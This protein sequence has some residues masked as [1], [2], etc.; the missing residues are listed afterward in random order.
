MKKRHQKLGESRKDELIRALKESEERY[1]SLVIATAQVV[2]TTDPD[3]QVQ[4][5]PMWREFTGQSEEEVRGWGWLQALHP[6][7]REPTAK[8][9]AEAVASK[10]VCVT[11]YRVRRHD[12]LYR[13][14]AV[15]GVPVLKEDGTIREWVGICSDI[16]ESKEAALQQR[17]FVRDV[18]FSVSEGKLRLCDSDMDLPQKLSSACEAVSLTAESLRVLRRSAQRVAQENGFPPERWQDLLSAVSEAAMNAVVHAGGGEGLVCVGDKGTVQVW[19]EDQGKG[20][21]VYT[22]HRATLERGFTTAGSLGHGFWLMIRTADRIWLCTGTEGT[23]VVIEQDRV[24]PEP[25]WLAEA[26]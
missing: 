8:M 26:A 3:G 9:W 13:Y 25:P 23:T 20:I 24:M 4:D 21:A 11:E 2:W 10:Q 19:I 12:G 17:R 16:T 5:M 6:D 18:L 7:D 22:L 14:L 1:R 15:R